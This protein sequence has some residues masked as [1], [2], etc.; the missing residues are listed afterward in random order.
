[1]HH[2][3]SSFGHPFPQKMLH[4]KFRFFRSVSDEKIVLARCDG[5]RIRFR[6]RL[7]GTALQMLMYDLTQVGFSW[8]FSTGSLSAFIDTH[9]EER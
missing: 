6:G 3:I 8:T 4:H 2:L 1:M 7:S 9:Q 5:Q